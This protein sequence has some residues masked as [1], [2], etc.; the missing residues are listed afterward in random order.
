MSNVDIWKHLSRQKEEFV[1]LPSEHSSICPNIR[2]QLT[3]NGDPLL[4]STLVCLSVSVI[5]ALH[6]TCSLDSES[7]LVQDTPDLSTGCR[8]KLCPLSC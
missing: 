5:F 2:T 4:L 6:A 3:D 8:L 1:T 7:W